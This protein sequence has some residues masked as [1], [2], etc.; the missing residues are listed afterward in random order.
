MTKMRPNGTKQQRKREQRQK[1]LKRHPPRLGHES[2]M[3]IPAF[4][5]A[6][7]ALSESLRVTP[8]TPVR[9]VSEDDF[10]LPAVDSMLQSRLAIV[11]Q[12]HGWSDEDVL[13]EAQQ[14]CTH[15]AAAVNHDLV[16]KKTF[17][18][19]ADLAEALL[20]TNL[21]IPGDVLELPFAACAFVFNDAPTIELVRSL[22]HRHSTARGVY[23]TLTVYAFPSRD[24]TEPGFDFVF[25]ADA[26]DG[27]WPYMM[28][29]SVLTDGKR[30]LDEILQSHPDG[31]TD[32]LFRD[33]DMGKLLTLVVNAVLYT[34]S[35]D[36]RKEWREPAPPALAPTVRSSAATASTTCP[37]GYRSAPSKPPRGG[38]DRKPARRSSSASGCAVIGVAPTA[39]GKT[40][41]YVGSLLT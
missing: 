40:N 23:R 22:I 27:E 33:V 19:S 25:L 12:L 36:Y 17:W 18:V 7:A 26:Y 39:A 28:G 35:A 20:H 24:V 15:L 34:T 31:A 30:N 1:R 5:A 32:E 3:A 21:D 6:A 10:A 38:P 14:L 8:G 37:A 11:R 41:A 16:G 2:M 4:R 13:T 29:R 9:L